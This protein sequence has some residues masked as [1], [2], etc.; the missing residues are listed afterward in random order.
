M[1]SE[2]QEPTMQLLDA[3]IRSLPTLRFGDSGESVRVLQRILRSNGYPV[4]VDGSF[5]ALTESAVKAFQTRR[6][7]V[8]DGV[9]GPK[10]WRE[11]TR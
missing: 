6:G 8:A 1:E 7:L 4:T 9:V 11:L 5:G 2:Y 10:T 3:S